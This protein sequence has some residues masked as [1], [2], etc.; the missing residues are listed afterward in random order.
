MRW[1]NKCMWW[2]TLAPFYIALGWG[3]LIVQMSN[4]NDE[5]QSGVERSLDNASYIL[6]TTPVLG[7]VDFIIFLDELTLKKFPQK[8]GQEISSIQLDS[9]AW[10]AHCSALDNMIPYK[11]KLNQFEVE[12][13]SV[14]FPEFFLMV[15]FSVDKNV[16]EI[17]LLAFLWAIHSKQSRHLSKNRPGRKFVWDL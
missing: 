13:K 14:S 6:V 1:Y 9:N 3:W 7:R 15:R 8:F 17:N 2:V 5:E 12:V 16:T 4:S 10:S 11:R